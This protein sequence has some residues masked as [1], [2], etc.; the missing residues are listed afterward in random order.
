MEFNYVQALDYLIQTSYQRGMSQAQL[1][2][3]ICDP[4]NFSK[5]CSG[6]RHV[7]GD[8]IIQLALKLNIS[9]QDLSIHATLENPNAYLKTM[10]QF[11]RLFANE[12]FRAIKKLYLTTQNTLDT[13]SKQ[14]EQLLLW[15]KGIYEEYVHYNPSYTIELCKKAI[16]LTNPYFCFD[17]QNLDVLTELELDIYLSLIHGYTGCEELNPKPYETQFLYPLD[18]TLAVIEELSRRQNV[19]DFT[20]LP[21]Y[22]SL[23][24]LM[25]G[26]RENPDALLLAVNKGIQ[27]GQ[28]NLEFSVTPELYMSLVV[29]ERLNNRPEQAVKKFYE[30]LYLYKL[31]N[32]SPSFYKNIS[33]FIR[34]QNLQV[35][36]EK[37]NQLLPKPMI[38]K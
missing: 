27:Y 9:L 11:K 18:L 21:K 8:L 14:F 32:K 37:L 12:D 15:M 22:C 7:S 16:H 31:Q 25:Y 4:S 6:K 2:E 33:H 17:K 36:V 3:G 30:C 5:I 10:K 34:T 1:C 29:Y 19:K 20:L 28:E 23:A 13:P 26:I 35:D 24:S 38:S